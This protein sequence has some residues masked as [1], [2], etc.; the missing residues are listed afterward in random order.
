MVVE[1]LFDGVY[2][3]NGRLYTVNLTPNYSVYG[4]E[5]VEMGG[6]QY[7]GWNPYRSKLAAAI[8]NGLKTFK[9]GEGT[10]VLYIGGATGTTV[11]HI[12]DII[13]RRGRAY[14]IELSE[15]N[16]RELVKVCEAKGNILPILADASIPDSYSDMVGDCDVIYQDASARDQAAL[17]LANTRFLKKGGYAYFIIKSQSIAVSKKPAEIFKE[18]LRKVSVA[19]D[20]VEKVEIEPYDMLHMFA[21]LKK[22]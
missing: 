20:V 1:K 17:L 6:I 21:V 3:V 10:S 22:R 11:S 8:M 16:M 5:L 9:F 19:Y 12:S 7:R 18:E 15:R 4:E 13:G 2:R 14:C